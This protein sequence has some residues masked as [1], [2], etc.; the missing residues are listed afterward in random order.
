MNYMTPETGSPDGSSYYNTMMWDRVYTNEKHIIEGSDGLGRYDSTTEGLLSYRNATY[1]EV[2]WY[3]VSNSYVSS[4]DIYDYY[5]YLPSDAFEATKSNWNYN[6]IDTA[7]HYYYDE[8]DEDVEYED[9]NHWCLSPYNRDGSLNKEFPRNFGVI[10]AFNSFQGIV[11]TKIL[12]DLTTQNDGSSWKTAS[13]VATARYT[14]ACCCARYKT[15]GTKAF[16]DCT[17][18][19]LKQGTGFWYFPAAGEVAYLIVRQKLINDTISKL[20][21]K[22]GIGK[23]ARGGAVITSTNY[24]QYT[25]GIQVYYGVVEY[26]LSDGQISPTA[27]RSNTSLAYAFMRL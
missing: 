16:V 13:N 9:K 15:N 24:G 14:Y 8:D 11:Y 21:S 4:Q 25:R 1:I 7:T 3:N 27:R 12:T 5:M 10:N 18:E 19:E 23:E 6:P 2:D 20:K 17:A 26:S 22:Y